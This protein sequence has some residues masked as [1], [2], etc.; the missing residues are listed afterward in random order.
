[1]FVKVGEK[2]VKHDCMKSDP[3][4]ESLWIIAFDKQKLESVDH[5]KHEL[6]LEKLNKI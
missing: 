2:E 4:D 5:N 6:N 3:P 1:M